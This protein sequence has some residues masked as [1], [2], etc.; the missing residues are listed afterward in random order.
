METKIRQYY[1]AV[2]TCWKLKYDKVHLMETKICQYCLVK[3][4]RRKLEYDNIIY[5]GTR[6]RN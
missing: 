5:L 4:M 2:Y 3:Y 6:D 1:L